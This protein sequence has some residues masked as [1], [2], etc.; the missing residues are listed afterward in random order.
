MVHFF[1]GRDVFPALSAII[2]FFNFESHVKKNR[3]K[4]NHK[5]VGS[6]LL[7]KKER[8]VL[9]TIFSNKKK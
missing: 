5:E 6:F 2:F 9:P 1:E 4:T 3:E 7:L 8:K